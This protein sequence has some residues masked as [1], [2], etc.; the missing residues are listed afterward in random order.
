MPVWPVTFCSTDDNR[1]LTGFWRAAAPDFHQS[2]NI[3]KSSLRGLEN[4][5]NPR[6]YGG[7]SLG[8]ANTKDLLVFSDASEKAMAACAY[9]S[10]TSV[11]GEQW[12]GFVWGQ[13]S[14]HQ[15]M[16]HSA[17]I[18]TLCSISRHRTVR[19]YCHGVW[20]QL[21]LRLF[22]YGQ[23]GGIRLFAY[24]DRVCRCSKL[25]D[26]KY[27]TTKMNPADE[28][29]LSVAVRDMQDS[30]FDQWAT[31]TTGWSW[32]VRF[33]LSELW[34]GPVTFMSHD[35]NAFFGSDWAMT[36]LNNLP[37]CI[38]LFGLFRRFN[39]WY[40]VSFLRQIRTRSGVKINA[41]FCCECYAGWVFPK[42]YRGTFNPQTCSPLKFDLRT[43]SVFW[44]CRISHC[45]RSQTFATFG[46]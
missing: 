29:T 23:L 40:L 21:W 33:C 7:L 8:V 18:K 44:W 28:G 37:T 4:V 42:R 32:I 6:T 11:S 19:C 9:V 45:L 5:R 36:E 31:L 13:P 38:C 1:W 14:W 30:L 43:W 2:W 25:R 39:M 34:S 22:L 35:G 17:T 15:S 16:E 41:P 10:L 24:V 3:W 27:A 26:W 12:L 20:H 46:S